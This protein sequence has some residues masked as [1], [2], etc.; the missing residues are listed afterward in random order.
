MAR[1]NS[2]TQLISYE[3]SIKKSNELSMAK[4]Y[5]GLSLNQMQLLAYSIFCTQKNGI[6][7]FRKADFEKKFGMS[8]YRTEDAMKDSDKITSIK[9]STSDMKNEKFKF[10]NAFMGMSYDKGHFSFEW[11]PKMLPHILEVQESLYVTIDLTI[12]SNFKSSFSWTLYDYLKAHHG[13]WYK[14]VS[15]EELMELFGVQNVKS[16]QENTGLFK[17]R[18][19]D[20]AIKEIETFT[21]LEVPYK[22]EKKGRAITGFRLEWSTGTKITSATQKQI[23]EIQSIIDIVFDDMFQYVNINDETDRQRAITLMQEIEE[24]RLYTIESIG[25]TSEK[26]SNLIQ[27]AAWNFRELNRLLEKNHKPVSSESKKKVE[28]YNWLEDRG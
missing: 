25:I 7:E 14:V 1:M 22:L 17:K 15:K 4:L 6:T 5:Q 20:V 10:W 2:K 9:F 23:K 27:K 24:M 8:Q 19:L 3:N 18:V 16:Y 12:A 11:S 28:F 26:A 13:Y 21:E